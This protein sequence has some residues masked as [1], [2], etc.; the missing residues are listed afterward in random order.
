MNHVI[1]F[2]DD[3]YRIVKHI[4]RKDLEKFWPDGIKSFKAH[5]PITMIYSIDNDKG[6]GSKTKT[7]S[8]L[9]IKAKD[10]RMIF[11]L[12]SHPR[13]QSLFET[14]AQLKHC[15]YAMSLVA[16]NIGPSFPVRFFCV[17]I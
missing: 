14:M 7:M 4:T 3:S 11:T 9:N 6:N 5:P 17:K 8:L 10:Q 13:N 1:L 15:T 2:S 16:K 12:Q